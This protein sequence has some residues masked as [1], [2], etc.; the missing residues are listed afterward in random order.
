MEK[1]RSPLRAIALLTSDGAVRCALL[2]LLGETDDVAHQALKESAWNLAYTEGFQQVVLSLMVV[3]PLV[4]HG[5]AQN[6]WL[7]ATAWMTVDWMAREALLQVLGETAQ[8]A[9]AELVE[10][11]W[12]DFLDV[13]DQVQRQA[14]IRAMGLDE[15][16]V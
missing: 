12:M 5:S 7:R 3:K 4:E 11:D 2:K 14:L 9:L 16:L 10:S 8:Q 1:A 6:Y 13:D 15:R